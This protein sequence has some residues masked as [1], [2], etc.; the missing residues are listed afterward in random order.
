MIP[1]QIVAA[2]REK[3]RE[4]KEAIGRAGGFLPPA[5]HLAERVLPPAVHTAQA[6]AAAARASRSEATGARDA[7]GPASGRPP[8]ANRGVEQPWEPDVGPGVTWGELLAGGLDSVAVNVSPTLDAFLVDHVVRLVATQ[9]G[10]VT[11][12]VAATGGRGFECRETWRVALPS[13]EFAF[14]RYSRPQRASNV[15]GASF[16]LWDLQGGAATRLVVGGIHAS[17]LGHESTV[18]R[19]DV[20]FD[21]AVAVDFYATSLRE[22]VREHVERR[23]GVLGEDE[24]VFE[25]G[26]PERRGTVYDGPRGLVRMVR[27]YRRDFKGSTADPVLR[28]EVELRERHARD[29]WSA[30]LLDAARALRMASTHIWERLGLDLGA[31]EELP[32]P[33]EEREVDAVRTSVHLFAQW[34]TVLGLLFERGVGVERIARLVASCA[35]RASLDRLERRRATIASMTVEELE[36]LIVAGLAL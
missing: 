15:L 27:I 17:G 24:D 29:L 12:D 21:F 8:R 19:V 20:A 1:R 2:R 11:R 18:S 16:V 23:E 13:I 10:T 9:G 34:S 28:V 22:L 30:Y 26:G 6:G 36:A 31:V 7:E 3:A 4:L 25:H 32:A 14:V 5:V 33:S 35:S